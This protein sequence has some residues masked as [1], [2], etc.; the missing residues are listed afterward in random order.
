MPSDANPTAQALRTLELLQ[1]RPG[2]TAD[3]L[4][5]Q[6]GVSERAARRYVGVLRD[7]GIPV[8][9]VTGPYGGYRLGRT[10][11]PAPLRFTAG[12]ALALVMAVL[13]G[14]HDADDT[15]EL[16]G[17]ALGKL[18]A[19][20]PEAVGAHAQAV[21]RATA[22]TPDRTAARPD[23]ATAAALVQASVQ[24]RR[25]QLDYRSHSGSQWLVEV[26]PWAVV[27]RHARWY[28][29][30][31][32]LGADARRAYRID[33]VRAARVLDDTFDVPGDT[34]PVATLEEHLASGREYA[35]D[36]VIDAPLDVVAHRMPRILGRLQPVDDTACRLV[37]ST[38]DP[39]WYTQQL[40][41]IPVHYRIRGGPSSARR[42]AASGSG[43]SPPPNDR[44]SQRRAGNYS[45]PRRT[46]GPAQQLTCDPRAEPATPSLPQP[47][48]AGCIALDRQFRTVPWGQVGPDGDL[49]DRVAV[50]GHPQ[51]VELPTGQRAVV[52]E[53]GGRDVLVDPPPKVVTATIP[54][55]VTAQTCVRRAGHVRYCGGPWSPGGT[56]G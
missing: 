37:A 36:V 24:R 40:A 13:D 6:L 25:V 56:D 46:S 28:L 55:L 4:G 52:D 20:L 3:R 32:S 22:S 50:A 51:H 34:D 17:S 27:V 14:Q 7:A 16:A 12:E 45:V 54:A 44:A 30:C 1:D 53:R 48:N 10:L 9:S 8:E 23:P 21:R 47:S 11:R 35:V 43:C 2:I 33:R 5:A 38:S 15:T 42:H 41:P 49:G 39:S 31:R 18:L 26:E 19:V 29:L